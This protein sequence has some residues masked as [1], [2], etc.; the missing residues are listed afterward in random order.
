M[1]DLTEGLPTNKEIVKFQ[2]LDEL[3]ESVYVEVKELSKKKPDDALNK[4][5]VK[6]VNRILVELKEFLKKEPTVDFL[7]LLDEEALPTN[8]DAILV[9]GQFKASMDNFRKKYR[10]MYGKWR[11]VENPSAKGGMD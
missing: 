2:M 6:N 4:F 8:S 7:D 10:N 9:I 1:R 11:T 3:A 5:K